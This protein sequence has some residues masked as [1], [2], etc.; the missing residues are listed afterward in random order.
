[1]RRSITL[2]SEQIGSPSLDSQYL[3]FRGPRVA[4]HRP[5]HLQ[6]LLELREENPGAKVNTIITSKLELRLVLL[7]ASSTMYHL[8]LLTVCLL[9]WS[10]WIAT[11]Q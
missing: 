10:V 1:M 6:Q 9:L 2:F 8:E 7:V 11:L 5:T 3:V 4:W